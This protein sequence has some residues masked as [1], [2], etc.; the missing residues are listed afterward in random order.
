MGLAGIESM[1]TEGEWIWSKK[2]WFEQMKICIFG[3]TKYKLLSCNVKPFQTSQ[4]HVAIFAVR[5]TDLK[6]NLLD[7]SLNA[8]TMSKS[9]LSLR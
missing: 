7:C 5:R 2:S 4:A 6:S 9:L 8:T 3:K 1:I